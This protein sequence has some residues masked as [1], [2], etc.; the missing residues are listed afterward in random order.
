M[1]KLFVRKWV[2][3]VKVLQKEG[4]NEKEERAGE[5]SEKEEEEE[6]EGKNEEEEGDENENGNGKEGKMFN[7]K[8]CVKSFGS[9]NDYEIHRKVKHSE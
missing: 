2:R 9:E 4:E 3:T 1:P 8:V 6:E 7:C 5:I